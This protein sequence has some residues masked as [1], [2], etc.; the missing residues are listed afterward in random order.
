MT[1]RELD[2]FIKNLNKNKLKS[3]RRFSAISEVRNKERFRLKVK[4]IYILK[5][6]LKDTYLM[7]VKNYKKDPKYRYFL[8]H[9]LA[10]VSS[11]LLVY[12]AKDFA[13]EHDL[14]LIQYSLYPKLL[15]L[16]LLSLKEIIDIENY[17]NILTLFKEFDDIFKKRL[18]NI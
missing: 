12:L 11:D 17:S 4:N 5:D 2:Q 3:A 1:K 14:K 18:K 15:R 13:V 9:S 6:I 10:S 7:V 8:A 16:N